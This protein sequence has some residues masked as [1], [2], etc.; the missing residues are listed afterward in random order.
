MSIFGKRK[1]PDE[2]KGKMEAQRRESEQAL[3]YMTAVLKR[4]DELLAEAINQTGTAVRP[5]RRAK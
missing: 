2:V 5:Q 1:L 4:K 3:A